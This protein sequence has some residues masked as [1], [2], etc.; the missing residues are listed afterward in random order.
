MFNLDTIQLIDFQDGIITIPDHSFDLCVS[1]PPFLWNKTT[2]GLST[3]SVITS[4][5]DNS[6]FLAGGKTASMNNT[7]KFKDWMPHLYR[8]MKDP[9]H[10]YLFTNDKN[11]SD[12]ITIAEESGFRLH[13]VLVWAKNNKTPNLW[14]MKNCEFIVFLHKGKSFRITDPSSAQLLSYSNIPGKSKLHPTQK[15]VELL[16]I[17]IQNSSQPGQVVFDP[18]MGSGSTAVAAQECGRHFFGFE[19]DPRFHQTALQRL[20]P[21]NQ[22]QLS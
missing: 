5:W 6:N 13:N 14:Y 17:L 11:L 19:N 20:M 1:D 3:T 4:K 15:P 9:S 10:I 8:V 12:L 2:G 18:F 7:I 22:N 21:N 16:K